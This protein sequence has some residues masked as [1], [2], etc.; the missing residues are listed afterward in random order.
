MTSE[1]ILSGLFKATLHKI[2]HHF[3]ERLRKLWSFQS[4]ET[5]EGSCEKE[6]LFISFFL[7]FRSILQ[8][9]FKITTGYKML[10]I[11]ELFKLKRNTLTFPG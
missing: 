4:L 6:R 9:L 7:P 3:E 8:V 1:A 5:G 11:Y 10:R 2:G